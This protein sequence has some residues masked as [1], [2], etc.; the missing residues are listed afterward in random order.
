MFIAQA[1]R[2]KNDLWRYIVGVVS[3]F[4]V[5]QL[6]A[7][8]LLFAVMLKTMNEG[9]NIGTLQDTTTLLTVLDPNLTFFLMLLSFAFGLG[10]LVLI[11]RYLHNQSFRS[12]TTSR[13]KIDWKRVFFAFGLVGGVSL[14][15]TGID[16]FMNPEDYV[17]QFEPQSFIIL[18]LIALF[19][20]PLQTSFEEYLFRGYLMQGIGVNA[21]DRF[22]PLVLTSVIFGGLHFFNPEV[23]KVGNIIMV[24]Y[25]GTGFFL[26]I[27]TL[28]DEGLELALGYH[29]ANNFFGAVLV[30][31][32]WT[33]FQTPSILKSVADPT[34]GMDVL[35]PV[36][37]VY[38]LIL[39]LFAWKYKWRGWKE[40]LTGTV[41]ESVQTMSKEF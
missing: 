20:I 28:M 23:T 22:L 33:V 4:L 29:A 7:I 19:M 12:L 15:M 35:V 34:S 13:S 11:V 5:S 36:F 17:V 21:R 2:V 27:M 25:I 40:K 37:V 41:T 39:L 16:Y 3:A 14:I 18:F 9:G 26:G 24:Y 6:G 8:P 30:T 1:F 10:A 31:A 32:D 38:P